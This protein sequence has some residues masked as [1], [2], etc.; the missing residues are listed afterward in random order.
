[1]ASQC[2]WHPGVNDVLPR[3]KPEEVH[4]NPRMVQMPCLQWYY[5]VRAT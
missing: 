3:V 2:V 5:C 4:H 1:M